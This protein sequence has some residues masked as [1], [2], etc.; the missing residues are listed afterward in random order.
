MEAFVGVDVGTASARAGVFD[1]A[2]RLLACAR[3]PIK[4]WRERGG[5]V[6]HSSADIFA[7]A[8]AAV[9]E[10]VARAGAPRIA[11]IGFDATCSLVALD[12]DGCSLPVGASGCAERDTIVWMDHRAVAE[13]AEINAGGHDILSYE[14]GSLSPE[15]QAPKLLWLARHR[16]DTFAH[17]RFFDLADFLTFRATGSLARSACTV[18]CKWPYDAPAGRWSADFF[19]R[20]GLG[21]LA[22]ENFARIGAEIVA[23]GAP[24]GAGLTREAAER[25]GLAPGTPVGA[26]LIDAYAGALGVIGGAPGDLQRRAALV[27]GTSSCCMV[28]SETPR[29]VPAVWGPYLSVLTPD[30]WVSEAGQSAFGAAIDRLL[31]LF[32]GPAVD[33]P[34][35]EG[36]LV[37]GAGSHSAAALIARDVHVLPDFLGNRS[38][39]ADPDARAGIIGLDLDEDDA[40]RDAVYLAGL[41]GL[42]QNLAQVLRRLES[43][44]FALDMLIASGGAAHSALVRQIVADAT[45]RPVAAAE[46]PEPVLLGAAMLG[47]VAAGRYTMRG[48]MTAMSR[49]KE[50]R[51]P[52][53]GE[54][55]AFHAKKRAAFETLQ[56]TERRLRETML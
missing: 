40:A 18:T 42:A 29:F 49:I 5:F 20:H 55:A 12:A 47:A 31:R 41:C 17:A 21:A 3:R 14:G 27:L 39:F 22:R 23:P 28:M 56:Q 4:L 33:F 30:Y 48:A 54:I 37:R 44:G 32:P 46:T 19:E 43:G 38:P 13:A 35:F 50:V 51:E 1:A 53:G 10:A 8:T 9:R 6:E 26:G 11:G 7:A 16:P 15:M 2:G 24:L 52:A 45:G 36:R 34:T 25:T